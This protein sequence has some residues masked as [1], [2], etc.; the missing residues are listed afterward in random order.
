MNNEFLV[1]QG[2]NRFLVGW[3]SDYASRHP[4]KVNKLFRQLGNCETPS[5]VDKT[6]LQFYLDNGKPEL[7][8]IYLETFITEFKRL[9]R[10]SRN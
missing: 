5:D 9:Q 8:K 7:F 3:I 4:R 1:Q 10:E 6:M 2:W